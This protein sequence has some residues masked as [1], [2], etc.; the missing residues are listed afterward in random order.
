MRSV[1]KGFYNNSTS[2][3]RV[4]HS[5]IHDLAHK[6]FDFLYQSV[7][8]CTEILSITLKLRIVSMQV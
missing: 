7:D 4:L 2:L 5:F 1:R 8:C 6:R 3:A